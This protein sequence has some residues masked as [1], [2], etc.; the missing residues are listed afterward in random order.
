M[1]F[2]KPN[3][4]LNLLDEIT[5]SQK[6]GVNLDPSKTP[7]P[8]II[9]PVM[10]TPGNLSLGN[11][12]QFLEVGAYEDVSSNMMRRDEVTRTICGREVKF[13]IYD[14]V[15]DFTDSR[16]SRVVAVFVTGLES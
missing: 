12:K 15:N 13:D 14:Q 10:H 11:A 9:V 8:I 6:G 16:W 1:H 7:R 4:Q 2:L 5:R 3:L